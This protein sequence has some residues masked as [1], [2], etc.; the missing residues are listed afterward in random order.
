MEMRFQARLYDC[1]HESLEVTAIAHFAT[2]VEAGNA[3]EAAVFVAGPTYCGD[4]VPGTLVVDYD[5]IGEFPGLE[6]PKQILEFWDGADGTG[7]GWFDDYGY[8]KYRAG[9]WQGTVLM[10]V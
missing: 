4:I 2:P 8:A 3:V 9:K 1:G 5:E 10:T 7:A 6:T